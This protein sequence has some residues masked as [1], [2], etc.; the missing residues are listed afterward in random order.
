MQD[1]DDMS[2]LSYGNDSAL[3]TLVFRY[4]KLLYGYAYRLL[5]MKG[6]RRILF[7]KPF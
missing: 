7:R 1:E 3:D 2:Q 5:R 4:H 6:W